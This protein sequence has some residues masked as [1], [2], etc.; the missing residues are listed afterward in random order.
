MIFKWYRKDFGSVPQF[1]SRYGPLGN[2]TKIDYKPYHWGLNDIGD[3]GKD[4]TNGEFVR[5]KI[6]SVFQ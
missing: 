2:Y 6:R 1:L 4:Y 5:A 3:M